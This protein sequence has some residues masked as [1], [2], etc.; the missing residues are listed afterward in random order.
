MNKQPRLAAGRA[1]ALGLP[2]RGTTNPNRLRRMDNWIATVLAGRLSSAAHP[3]V[4]DLGYGASPITAV[5]LLSRL[6]RVRPDVEL[7]G[8]EIDADRVATAQSATASGLR[9]ERGGFELAGHQPAIVRA[10]NVLRQYPE[11]AVAEAWQRMQHQLAPGGVLVEGTCDEVGRRG[12]W[13]LLDRDTPISLTLS[14]RLDAVHRPSEV[15]ERLV[16]ALIHRNVSGEPIHALLRAM[17]AGWDR[18]APLA[19]FGS[20]QRWQAMC[21]DLGTDWPVLSTPGRHRFGE[22]TVAWDAVAPRA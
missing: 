7:L 13:V 12:S 22:L 17:D 1:R 15:A 14:C 21:A 9:F 20:R 4:I 18:H 19:S 5:E 10:A 16:K 6:R 8:L 3:L 11:P 2:T